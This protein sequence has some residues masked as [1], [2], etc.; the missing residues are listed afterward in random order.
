MLTGDGR[1][2]GPSLPESSTFRGDISLPISRSTSSESNP[3]LL[4]LFPSLLA[5]F[6]VPNFVTPLCRFAFLLRFPFLTILTLP[7]THFQIR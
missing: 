5:L 6:L 4:N 1:G 7:L 2:V 3:I